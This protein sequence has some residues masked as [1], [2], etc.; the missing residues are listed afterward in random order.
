MHIFSR[1]SPAGSYTIE[2]QLQAFCN[3]CNKHLET[4]DEH[5]DNLETDFSNG[6]KLI[7]L[8][9]ALSKKKIPDIPR[10][11]P[12]KYRVQRLH[13]VSMALSFLQETEHVIFTGVGAESFVDGD[14][15][16]VLALVW[17][18]IRHYSKLGQGGEIKNLKKTL[19]EWLREKLPSLNISNFKE[20]WRDG[21]ALGALIDVLV[22][23]AFPDW[24]VWKKE[25]ASGNIV[26]AM[27]FAA[28]WLNVYKLVTAENILNP[29]TDEKAII[30]YIEQ[31]CH[32]TPDEIISAKIGLE[33]SSKSQNNIV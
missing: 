10:R 13:L 32:C 12:P 21:R 6:L 8:V 14:R 11:R 3:W 20:D 18:L 7:A 5:I 9:E 25:D 17:L 23:G 2:T 16:Y 29:Q 26:Q 19:L 33:R 4:V 24:Q 28:N 22:P 31:F 30:T 27:D 1:S 15:R